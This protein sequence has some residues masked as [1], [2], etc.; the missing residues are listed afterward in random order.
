MATEVVAT[1]IGGG[2]TV[3]GWFILNRLDR[4]MEDRK[5]AIELRIAYA[6]RQIEEFYGPLLNLMRQVFVLYAIQQALTTARNGNGEPCLSK[7]QASKVLDHLQNNGF[8]P[9]HTCINDILKSKM[10]LIHGSQVPKSIGQYLR[11]S[12][13]EREQ[14]RLWNEKEIDTTFLKGKPF[15]LGL[16]NDIKAG[17]DL[18]MQA[19][20]D[21]LQAKFRLMN[22][23]MPFHYKAGAGVGPP[24]EMQSVP[25]GSA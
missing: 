2:I 14:R 18:A 11:H 15:P 19:Y 1:L 20:E 22:Q 23:Y 3:I 10:H 4:R 25:Q 17:F 16:Y 9:L 8:I 6:A 7:D 12:L 13:Q 24:K 21:S 5:M